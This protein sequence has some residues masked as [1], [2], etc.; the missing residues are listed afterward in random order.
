MTIWQK[1]KQAR[2]LLVVFTAAALVTAIACS[3]DDDD[4]PPTA[5]P[6]ATAAES[7]TETTAA[8]TPADDAV[9]PLAVS[10]EEGDL[11]TY[12]AG[13]DGKALYVFTRDGAN[14]SNCIDDCLATWPPLLLTE[15]QSVEADAGATGAF[16]S[17]ETPAGQLVT[18]NGAPL[19][20]FAADAAPGDTNGHLVGNVWFLARPETA[21]TAYV[22]V[23]DTFLVGPTGL[24]LYLF[25]N[26]TEGVSNCSGQC[27]DNWPAL[28]VPEGLDPSAVSAAA[29]ALDVVTRD[30]GALQITYNGLPLYYFAGDSLPGDTN[31]DGVGGVWSLATP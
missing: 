31:G 16:D 5:A 18:Y 20:Y 17:I 2:I 21:S 8:P 11:G 9:E 29:G 7:P 12:L 30:D 4:A 22:G 10:I 25:A 27:L 14:T 28:T 3:G 6:A 24:T 19:Y 23:R 1:A 13:P 26:D 15:G